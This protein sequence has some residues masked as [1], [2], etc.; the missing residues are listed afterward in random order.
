MIILYKYMFV[1]GTH[2]S[3]IYVMVSLCIFV[4]SELYLMSDVPVLDTPISAL[5]FYRD[6]VATNL[7][8]LIKGAVNKWPAIRK[9]NLQF[10]RYS[11]E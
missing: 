10:L 6:W 1:H 9:W 11:L 7:P 8:V 4:R 5:E 3:H 2:T